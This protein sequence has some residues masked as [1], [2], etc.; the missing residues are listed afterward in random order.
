M[1]PQQ[2]GHAA[3]VGSSLMRNA[4]RSHVVVAVRADHACALLLQVLGEL[5]LAFFILRHRSS[6]APNSR[7]GTGSPGSLAGDG[8]APVV[9]LSLAPGPDESS[10]ISGTNPWLKRQTETANRLLLTRA[11]CERR[12]LILFPCLSLVALLAPDALT[13]SATE[14]TAAPTAAIASA[15]AFACPTCT[16][17]CMEI[18]KP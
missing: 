10:S 11:Q 1:A 14:Q 7:I 6:T 13:M 2:Q 16:L 17:G 8:A 12:N 3:F 15:A 5:L 9:L 18:E 4:S